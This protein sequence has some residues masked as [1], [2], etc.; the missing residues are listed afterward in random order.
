MFG[1]VSSN[2]G[3]ASYVADL[4]GDGCGDELTLTVMAESLVRPIRVVSDAE[5]GFSWNSVAV[6]RLAWLFGG[7]L[8]VLLFVVILCF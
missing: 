4:R 1:L 5:C 7:S 8:S 6:V 3:L 2:Y